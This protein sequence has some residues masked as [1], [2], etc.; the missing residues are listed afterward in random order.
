MGSYTV[1]ADV[2]RS[3]IEI[4]RSRLVPEPVKKAETIGLCPPNDRGN[5]I[6]GLYLYDIEEN[7]D[8]RS[9]EKII[10]D[11]EHYKDPPISLNLYYMLFAY[12]DSEPITRSIDEQRIL[13]RAIQ[14]LNDN[15]R[16]PEEYLQGTVKENHEN[17]DI[18]MINIGLDEKV[19]IW[20][21]FNQPYK[22]SAFY[23]VG[24][25]F[26]EADKIKSF[27]RVTEV[28]ISVQQK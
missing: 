13:A 23:K 2:S 7:P 26:M 22:I 10:L 6:L 28:N 3:I 20:S 1:I 12:S 25:V 15:R 4:L 24:P 18:Q 27:K 14:Q 5:N 11:K 21:L 19:K 16:I 9:R 8:T 17:I